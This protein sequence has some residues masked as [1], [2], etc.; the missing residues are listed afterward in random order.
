M[1]SHASVSGAYELEVTEEGIVVTSDDVR[2]NKG[3]RFDNV[4]EHFGFVERKVLPLKFVYDPSSNDPSISH[5][6]IC[7]SVVFRSIDEV[8]RNQ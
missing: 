1:A 8:A 6:I 3:G 5:F 2:G 4:F 7:H